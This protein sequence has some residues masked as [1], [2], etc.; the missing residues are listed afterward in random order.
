MT[1][2]IAREYSPNS[3][4][5]EDYCGCPMNLNH[6]RGD[7]LNTAVTVSTLHTLTSLHNSRAGNRDIFTVGQ[8]Q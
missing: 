8:F 3:M 2:I 6:G 7:R 5:R 4:W 1:G